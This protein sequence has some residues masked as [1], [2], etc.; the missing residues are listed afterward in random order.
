MGVRAQVSVRSTEDPIVLDVS[1]RDL[2]IL[3]GW[4]GE[5]LR[6]LQ[7]VTNV[8]V[9][10]HMSEHR[11]IVDVERYRQ[12]REHTVREIALRAARRES[13]AEKARPG[14]GTAEL[15][16]RGRGHAGRRASCRRLPRD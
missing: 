3:I 7:T 10:R 14:A 13:L 8:L 12:R 6:A 9:G 1:G 2:G 16:C 5:T 4:R 15:G 11:V